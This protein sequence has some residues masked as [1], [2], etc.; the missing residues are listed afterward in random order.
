MM[1][2]RGDPWSSNPN[3]FFGLALPLLKHGMPV[4]PV[5]MEHAQRPGYL[6]P[7]RLLLLSY[8]FMKPPSEQAHRA[9]AEWVQHGGVLV[10]VGDG[11]DPYATVPEWWN[12]E[13]MQFA[14]PEQHLFELLGLGQ[15][16]AAGRYR[17]GEGVVEIVRAHPTSFTHSQNDTQRLLDIAKR[18]WRAADIPGWREQNCVRLSR[19]PYVIA[20]VFDETTPRRLVIP[21]QVVDLFDPKLRVTAGKT[22]AP[23]QV[24]L[25]RVLTPGE[26]PKVVASASR[27]TDVRAGQREIAFHSQGPA[28]TTAATRIALPGPPKSVTVADANGSAY[29]FVSQWD[30]DTGTLLLCYEN[31]PDGVAVRVT[32]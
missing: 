22:L 11:S 27:V 12:T 25:L 29:G 2:Q 4:H 23:G 30:A 1:F 31:L 15:S 19:G 6:V 9:I 10:Y 5:Q 18:A 32:Y 7:Y 26:G 24:A 16:P 13:P 3:S 21:E 20:A 17:F 8:E 14:R 28:S